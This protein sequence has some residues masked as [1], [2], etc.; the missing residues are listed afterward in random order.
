MKYL[1]Y[2]I[3]LTA[4]VMLFALIQVT[5]AFGQNIS[6]SDTTAT[7]GVPESVSPAP[8]NLFGRNVH[9][10]IDGAVQLD[11]MHDFNSV[12]LDPNENFENEFITGDIPVGGP[13]ADRN[14]RTGFSPNQS[15]FSMWAS[16]PTRHGDFKVYCRFNLTKLVRGTQF[17]VYKVYGEWGWF[18]A[19]FDWTLWLNP[20]AVPNT[21]DFEG[22]NPIPTPRFAQVRVKIPLGTKGYFLCLGMEE[23]LADM[24]L[25]ANVSPL[26]KVPAFIGKV[27]YEPKRAHIEL[28]GL[29]RQLNANGED[30][31]M[32]VNGWGISLSGS[33]DTWGNDNVIFG[34]L[35]GEALGAY[36]DDTQGFGLDAVPNPNDSTSLKVI[37]ALGIWFAYDHRWAKAWQSTA[38]VG[39]VE[40]DNAFD[41]T[42]NPAGTFHKS[43]YVSANLIWSPL[44][45]FDLGIEYMYGERGVTANTAINGN[46]LGHNNR[47][48]MTFR[49]NFTAKK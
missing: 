33:I 3:I 21:L 30:I 16:T 46:R 45:A 23:A 20:D 19:G 9:L 42:P 36:I 26:N 8:M 28:A 44:P 18:K 43:L 5:T 17:Q 35:Y 40:L 32:S 22:P 7:A 39:Y 41:K 1:F 11:V 25:P 27:G 47:L 2:K 14:N 31:N 48:Q 37:P 6:S 10:G 38:T 12:G 15:T 4:V 49:W 34:G 13:A 24:T 29:Y